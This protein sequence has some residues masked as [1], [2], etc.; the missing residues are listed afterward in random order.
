M[1]NIL[2]VKLPNGEECEEHEE[3]DEVTG[4]SYFR[5]WVIGIKEIDKAEFHT[6]ETGKIKER[7]VLEDITA[8]IR[9]ARE[10]AMGKV[11][12]YPGAQRKDGVMKPDIPNKKGE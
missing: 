8:K 10:R 9:E 12:E 11:P 6:E 2:K 1:R 4:E 3:I 7:E 5:Y